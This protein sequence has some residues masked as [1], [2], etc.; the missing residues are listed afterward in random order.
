MELKKRIVCL[1]SSRKHNELCIA[2][3]EVIDD[4]PGAWIRPVSARPHEEVARS[5]CRLA[6][7]RTPQL[8]DI[9]DVPMAERRPSSYQRENWLIDSSRKWEFIA[10]AHANAL[11]AIVDEPPALWVNGYSTIAGLNDRVPERLAPELDSSLVMI[12]V[13]SVVYSTYAFPGAAPALRAE[14][15]VGDF[16]YRLRVTDPD[17]ERRFMTKP[18]TQLRAGAAYLTISLGELYRGFAYKLVAGVIETPASHRV[19]V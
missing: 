15:S 5:E 2:G 9:V 14:F 8:L 6:S 12:A 19:D 10:T 4:R 18:G 11:P 7:G 3:R 13:D 17:A 1:A 16:E